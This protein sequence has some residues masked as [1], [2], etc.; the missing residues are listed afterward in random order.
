MGG[1]RRSASCLRRRRRTYPSHP[2]ASRRTRS[3]TA[4]A[5]ASR[6]RRR[7]CRP[8]RKPGSGRILARRNFGYRTSGVVV[9]P[10][11]VPTDFFSQTIVARSRGCRAG[12]LSEIFCNSANR[13]TATARA[14]N[15][16]GKL[17]SAKI[18]AVLV[19]APRGS[20]SKAPALERRGVARESG[21]RCRPWKPGLAHSWRQTSICL[22]AA[23]RVLSMAASARYGRREPRSRPRAKRFIS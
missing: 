20:K 12:P 14:G 21:R 10:L 5:P 11:V 9:N 8:Y 13:G 4:R 22:H 18:W 19:M 17:A 6:R 15:L 1:A 7:C 16:L 2:P 23:E 3:H